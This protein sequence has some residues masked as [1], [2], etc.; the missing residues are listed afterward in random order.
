MK[1]LFRTGF[2]RPEFVAF[3]RLR[4]GQDA[5]DVSGEPTVMPSDQTT[6]ETGSGTSSSPLTYLPPA[7][8]GAA[9]APAPGQPA[10]ASSSS[11]SP[12]W[13]SQI[14]SAAG[15]AYAAAKL[16]GTKPT[17]PGVLR[18]PA[19]PN[20]GTILAIAGGALGVGLIAVLA[21]RK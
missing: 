10:G 12:D 16:P 18:P 19:G 8:P 5:T 4:L 21:F 17:A 15:K 13:I 14:I 7:Q 3:G 2:T 1:T 20:V 6:S 9:Q 11:T